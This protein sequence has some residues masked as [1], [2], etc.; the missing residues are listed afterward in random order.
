MQPRPSGVSR[1]LWQPGTSY[2]APVRARGGQAVRQGLSHPPH[3]AAPP[4]GNATATFSASA[5]RKLTHSPCTSCTKRRTGLSHT[6]PVRSAHDWNGCQG[7]PPKGNSAFAPGRRRSGR[8]PAATSGPP[9]RACRPAI[10]ARPSH[11][12]RT[13]PQGRSSAPSPCPAVAP[14]HHPQHRTRPAPPASP[15][16]AAPRSRPVSSQRWPGQ[17]PSAPQ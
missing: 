1:N 14:A 9:D 8:S 3:G 5:P 17:R 4:S 2:P 7:G 15:R 6:R 16:P 12:A 11:A 10:P 13:P